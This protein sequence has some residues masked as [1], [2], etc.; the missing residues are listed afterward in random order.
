[1]FDRQF[2]RRLR[3]H[4]LPAALVAAASLS[5]AAVPSAVAQTIVT[6]Q[7]LPGQ[8]DG[9]D[10]NSDEF[11]W[12]LLVKQIAVP[13]N[14]GQ[15]TPATFETWASDADVFTQTPHF[16]GI[17]EPHKFRSSL[18]GA[19]VNAQN[20]G[21]NSTVCNTP[22]GP[23]NPFIGGFPTS[24][25]PTTCIAEE[26]KRNRPEY[27]YIVNNNL[28]TQAGLA[29][30]FQRSFV[31]NMPAASISV[32][33]DWIP[34]STLIEWI[35]QLGNQTNVEK[36]YFTITLNGVGFALVSMHVSS[37]QNEKW[38]WGTFEH[39]MNP[40]RCDYLGCYDTYGAI[41]RAVPPNRRTYNTQYGE[42]RKNPALRNMMARGGLSPVWLNYCLKGTMVNFT[43]YGDRPSSLGNS[44]TEG[45]NAGVSVVAASCI[46]CHAYA[47]FGSNGS[48]SPAALAMLNQNPTGQLNP[49]VFAGARTY[50]FM[51]GFLLAP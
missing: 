43:S 2:F 48:A 39:Q 5:L 24:T 35:P 22:A 40:G 49:G 9:F 36:Q 13:V 18:L 12:R 31:V 8:V 14:P 16:P 30:A 46:T 27:D 33:G 26:V 10:G 41:D 45:I 15:P 28:Y 50:D 25:T 7:S 17:T 23:A 29:A 6:T 21:A 42:C 47:A 44:V 37:K 51:W 11:I 38:V 20:G 3:S 19:A 32:K 4:L 1:M 34:V